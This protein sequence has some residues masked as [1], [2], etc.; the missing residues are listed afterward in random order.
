MLVIYRNL[1][2]SI[3]E[4]PI[5]EIINIL[6]MLSFDPGTIVVIDRGLFDYQMFGDWTRNKVYFVT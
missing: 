5:H 2:I 4:G 3:T 6:K 1:S